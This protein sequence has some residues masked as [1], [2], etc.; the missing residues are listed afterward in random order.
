MFEARLE[1]GRT[2]DNQFECLTGGEPFRSTILTIASLP[3]QG[4]AQSSRVRR[5]CYLPFGQSGGQLLFHLISKLYKETSA[6]ITS[7]LAF[8]AWST[9]FGDPKITTALLNRITHLSD[10]VETGNDS[11]RLKNRN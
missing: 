9:V 7:N 1:S 10:I 8:G 4:P 3:A 6:I 5:A 2:V 11:W